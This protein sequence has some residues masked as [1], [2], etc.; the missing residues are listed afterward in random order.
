MKTIATLFALL[1]VA[2]ACPAQ[3]GVDVTSDYEFELRSVALAAQELYPDLADEAFA[4]GVP[5]MAVHDV[6]DVCESLTGQR[7]AACACINDSVECQAI[8]IGLEPTDGLCPDER[9]CGRPMGELVS[10]EYVHAI[11]RDKGAG[12]TEAFWDV[13]TLAQRLLH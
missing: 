11:L 1:T 3:G 9:G 4:R 10:H 2:C 13:F 12:H 8:I 5:V 6:V 7:V